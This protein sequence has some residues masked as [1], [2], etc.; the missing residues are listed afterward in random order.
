MKKN[1]CYG[2]I[3]EDT[4]SIYSMQ[5]SQVPKHSIM[6][7]QKQ[8][9][10]IM[11]ALGTIVALW[12]LEYILTAKS[13]DRKTEYMILL[14]SVLFWVVCCLWFEYIACGS[15]HSG[16]MLHFCKVVIGNIVV[17]LL[18]LLCIKNLCGIR[19]SL[20]VTAGLC[21]L[22]EI[23]NYFDVILRGENFVPWDTGLANEA[24]GVVDL[25]QLP[26]NKEMLVLVLM[27]VYVIFMICVI[28]KKTKIKVSGVSRIIAT[29]ILVLIGIGWTNYNFKFRNTYKIY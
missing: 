25:G 3:I 7:I 22:L 10:C 26:W 21:I 13:L 8:I 15:F 5:L 20:S 11:I 17:L 2:I 9:V 18:M 6:N 12:I 28:C 23:I 29:I 14:F 1:V 4:F 27:S 24:V 16:T 19:I